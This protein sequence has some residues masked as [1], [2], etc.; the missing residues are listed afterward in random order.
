V[1]DTRQI[2]PHRA[3]VEV[4]LDLSD[5]IMLENSDT[6]AADHARLLRMAATAWA[7]E[8]E[9]LT[10]DVVIHVSDPAFHRPSYEQGY[11]NG[12]NSLLADYDFALTEM[13]NFDWPEERDFYPS[14]VAAVIADLVKRIDDLEKRI[15]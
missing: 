10:G 2:R 12:A 14:D 7:Q 13:D 8:R 11:E 6:T 15:A 9:S 4:V 1:R 3:T 5:Q